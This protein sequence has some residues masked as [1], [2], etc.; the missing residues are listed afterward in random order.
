[1]KIK[2]KD[3][4]EEYEKCN[5]IRFLISSF[6]TKMQNRMLSL[7]RVATIFAVN[8]LYFYQEFQMFNAN[9]IINANIW[10]V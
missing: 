8:F 5:T 6:L 2:M 1:M 4:K 10:N 3:S 9:I 7:I